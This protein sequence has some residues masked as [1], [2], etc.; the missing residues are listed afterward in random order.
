[1]WHTHKQSFG[2]LKKFNQWSESG[3]LSSDQLEQQNNSY[4]FESVSVC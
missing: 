2:S 4:T 3:E 1:M